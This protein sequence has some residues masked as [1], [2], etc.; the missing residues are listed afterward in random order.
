MQFA[1]LKDDLRKPVSEIDRL[2]MQSGVLYSYHGAN[3]KFAEMFGTLSN[4]KF[5]IVDIENVCTLIKDGTHQTPIYTDDIV[6]GYKFLSSKDVMTESIDWSDVK[7]IPKALHAVLYSCVQPKR[8][9]IL[10]A[11]NGN[12]GVAAINDTDEIF[13]I[14]VSLALLRP[15]N[16]INPVY[17]K[18]VL[19]SPDTKQQFDTSIVGMGVPNLHLNKIKETKIMLP[20]IDL[21]NQFADYA[22]SCDKLK[23][24]A[25]EFIKNHSKDIHTK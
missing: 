24:E 13:D 19:N 8:N 25:R 5:N 17:F 11:K 12:Y 16:I 14:Y 6:N 1:E 15:S 7:Y 20:P 9:D 10:M 3:G 23:F 21:Q 22:Q 2:S 18:N 4:T